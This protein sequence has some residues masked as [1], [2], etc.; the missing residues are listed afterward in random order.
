MSQTLT[1]RG[2]LQSLLVRESH[3]AAEDSVVLLAEMFVQFAPPDTTH[4]SPGFPAVVY[5]AQITEHEAVRQARPGDR[6]EIVGHWHDIVLWA[7]LDTVETVS[8][9]YVD[10]FR[11]VGG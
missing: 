4:S 1:L 10:G 3:S 5:D 8:A 2:V 9:V 11:L 7:S 6:V